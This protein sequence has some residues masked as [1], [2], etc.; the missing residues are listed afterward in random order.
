[1]HDVDQSGLDQL[2]LRQRRGDAQ[3]RLVGK[4]HRALRHGMH[5]AG[6]AQGG[7]IV[8]HPLSEAAAAFEP[9]D[10][11]LRKTQRF[12][13]IERLLEPGRHQEAPPRR[14]LAHEELEHRGLALV[15]IEIGLHHVELVEIGQQR[16]GRGVITYLRYGRARHGKSGLPDCRALCVRTSGKAEFR[17]DPNVV[18]RNA[19][20]G[21]PEQVRPRSWR[22]LREAARVGVAALDRGEFKEFEHI[23][24]LQAY[25]NDLSEKVISRTAE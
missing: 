1:M 4:E 12:E 3:D 13:K 9:G 2:R 8:E 15:M 6:E 5:V 21:W 20:R 14:Q 16:A 11:L 17:A 10:V 23:E 22:V 25:L 7:K 19:S 18:L 24:D